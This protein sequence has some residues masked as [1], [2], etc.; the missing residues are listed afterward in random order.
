MGLGIN[1]N[2]IARQFARP[3]PGLN[4]DWQSLDAA[5][6]TATDPATGAAWA[7]SNVGGALAERSVKTVPNASEHAKLLGIYRF[8]GRVELPLH[9]PQSNP[10]VPG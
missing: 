6:W 3:A 2:G 10:G 9:F 5:V 1:L 7:I 4:E 8:P